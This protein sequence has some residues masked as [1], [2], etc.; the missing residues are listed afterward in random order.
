MDADQK[1]ARLLMQVSGTLLTSLS[2]AIAASD[3]MAK[4]LERQTGL[5]NAESLASQLAMLRRS[6]FQV[7]RVADNMKTLASLELNHAYL[8]KETVDLW[9]LC[10]DIADAVRVLVPDIPITVQPS[11]DTFLTSC[12][13]ELVERLLL[14]LIANSLRHCQAGEEIRIQLLRNDDTM[15]IILA[16]NGS[17]IPRETMETLFSD[18]LRD[19]DLSDTGRGAGLGLSVA[20]A[21]AKAHGGTLVITAEAEHGTKAVFSLP[22]AWAGGLHGS[23]AVYSSNSR[24]RAILTALSDVCDFHKFQSPF[25]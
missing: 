11:S 15:Q 16:D 6:Q 21:I 4:Q 7:L 19:I 5:E 10:A 24:F 20:E 22:H 23:R 25:L 2:S 18:Y 12:D 9:Q 14:N 1:T 17:G 3:L 8:M 13:P